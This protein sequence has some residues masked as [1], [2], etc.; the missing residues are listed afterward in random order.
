[1]ANS[2]V[3]L[4]RL[5]LA[6]YENKAKDIDGFKPVSAQ[7]FGIGAK[8]GPSSDIE[9]SFSGGVYKATVQGKLARQFD[10]TA[11]ATVHLSGKT[12]AVVFR[13]TDGT[14]LDK[15]L[16][17]GPQMK[18]A[19]W[20][21]YEPLMKAVESYVAT[22]DVDVVRFS[23]HSLGAAMAQYA[24]G[25]FADSSTTK[26]RAAIFG[27][28]GAVD[29]GNNDDKRMVAFEYSNDAFTKLESSPLIDFD[30]QGQRVVMPR[31]STRT[32]RD[33]KDGFYEHDMGRYL[34]GVRNLAQLGD[35]AP[36]VMTSDTYDPDASLRVYA[37]GKGDDRLRG[38]KGENDTLYGSGGDD[39]LWG[40][41]GNDKLR[42]GA[43][44][45]RLN[46]GSGRDTLTGGNGEDTFVFSNSRCCA[47]FRA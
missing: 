37:G 5:S 30:H 43:G 16:G 11:V 41:S 7:S 6:A 38:E 1:M 29:S 47:V 27:S 26:Y 31:D 12:L 33:D 25:E 18:F 46:G 8:S 21:L 9:W 4:A 22:H 14:A 45:D 10:D 28:P 32:T 20:P 35:A 39:F 3:T 40:L 44:D 17:W 23:G 15:V 36:K 19:Y 34:Q 42:G 24:M 13:G 2:I